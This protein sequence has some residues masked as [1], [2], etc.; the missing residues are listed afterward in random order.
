MKSLHF[1]LLILIFSVLVTRALGQNNFPDISPKWDNYYKSTP[2]GIEYN[3]SGNDFIKVIELVNFAPQSSQLQHDAQLLKK[4]IL[5]L[6]Q[7]DLRQMK[8]TGNYYSRTFKHDDYFELY[9]MYYKKLSKETWDKYCPYLL[10]LMD[11]DGV[12]NLK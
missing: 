5:N 2:S 8:I 12:V 9:N 3:F 4:V 6:D 1:L 10:P 11:L 7:A